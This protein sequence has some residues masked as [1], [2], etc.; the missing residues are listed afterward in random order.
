MSVRDQLSLL[1]LPPHISEAIDKKF[2]GNYDLCNR[3]TRHHGCDW[4]ARRL[5]LRNDPGTHA[6]LSPQSSLRDSRE[7]ARHRA[8]N[9]QASRPALGE[10]RRG[11]PRD[12]PSFPSPLCRDRPPQPAENRRCPSSTGRRVPA[13]GRP[14]RSWS[15]IVHPDRVLD[16]EGFARM[17]PVEP[18]YPSTEG[19]FQKSL[20]RAIDAALAKSP[21]CRSGMTGRR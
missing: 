9:S 6:S 15:Q 1:R 16:S 12:R 20:G 17:A 5:L 11:G 13:P 8:E 4:C 18:V 21:P 7:P 10:G 2:K 19:L 14:T 3:S